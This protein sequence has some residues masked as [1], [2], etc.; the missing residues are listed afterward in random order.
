MVIR[1]AEGKMF[2]VYNLTSKSLES[3]ENVAELLD[4]ALEAA[5][6]AAE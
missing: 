2:G 4:M 1:D 6:V 3:E 5:G